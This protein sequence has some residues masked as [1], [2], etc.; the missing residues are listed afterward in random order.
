MSS[1]IPIDSH[2]P[3][4]LFPSTIPFA[5]PSGGG[6]CVG[7]P[8]NHRKRL[9][10]A[11]P[12]RQKATQGL[13]SRFRRSSGPS[14]FHRILTDWNWSLSTLFFKIGLVKMKNMLPASV[15]VNPLLLMNQGVQFSVLATCAGSYS[16]PQYISSHGSRRGRQGEGQR[17]VRRGWLAPT[18]AGRPCMCSADTLEFPSVESLDFPCVTQVRRGFE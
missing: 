10:T 1:S 8:K 6:N 18:D 3:N 12:M 7:P 17:R 4:F 14:M 13:L 9:A 5:Q 2:H 11:Q 15:G 16:W